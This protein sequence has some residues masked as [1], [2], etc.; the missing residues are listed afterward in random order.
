M[1]IFLRHPIGIF[2]LLL[3][4]FFSVWTLLVSSDRID[5]LDFDTTVRI[6]DRFPERFDD[7]LASLVDLGSMEVQGLLLLFLLWRLPLQKRTKGLLLCGYCAGLAIVLV[8]KTFLSHPAPPY[9]FHR[10]NEG[11]SF[12]S[13]HVQVDSSYPSGH[14]YRTVFFATVAVFGAVVQRRRSLALY[15]IVVVA[16]ILGTLIPFG[17]VV[18]GKHWMTDVIGGTLLASGIASAGFLFEGLTGRKGNHAR[19]S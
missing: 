9:M 14:S 6:Q 4:S 2:G 15:S 13:L 17:L 8:G 1:R 18:L 11:L 10:G 19:S 7:T 3:M 16:T 12:P 5:Q